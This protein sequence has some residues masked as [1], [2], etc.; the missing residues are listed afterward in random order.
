MIASITN[1]MKKA[2]MV[3][4]MYYQS[5]RSY[6]D[7][8][9]RIEL[10]Y[11]GSVVTYTDPSDLETLRKWSMEAFVIYDHNKAE[12]NRH[13]VYQEEVRLSYISYMLNIGQFEEPRSGWRKHEFL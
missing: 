3:E 7:H 8:G 9:T 11:P 6:W 5:L 4:T 10:H 12:Y 2:D 13:N 1:W